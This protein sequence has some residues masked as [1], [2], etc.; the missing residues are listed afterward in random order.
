M[1]AF[2][3]F[4][5]PFIL[6]SLC[7][8]ACVLILRRWHGQE[9]NRPSALFYPDVSPFKTLKNVRLPFLRLPYTLLLI[10]LAALLLAWW[11]PPLAAKSPVSKWKKELPPLPSEGMAFYLLLDRSGSMQQP[12]PLS[13]PQVRKIDLL[14]QSTSRLIGNTSIAPQDLDQEPAVDSFASDLIGIIG[15]ARSAQ[16]LSPLTLDRARLQEVLSQ[17]HVVQNE[18]EDGTGIGYAIFKAVQLIAATKEL[19]AKET[20][21]TAQHYKPQQYD[22]QNAFLIILT[23]GFQDPNPLDQGKWLRTMGLEEAAGYAKAEGVKIYIINM[24]P[25]LEKEQFAPHRRLLESI[26]Q[27]T[28]GQFFL[29]SKANTLDALYQTIRERE[30]SLLPLGFVSTKEPSI[31]KGRDPSALVPYLLMLALLCL[32]ASTIALSTSHRVVP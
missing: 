27:M 14:K 6:S 17:F 16:V 19:S 22:I 11:N 10:A 21:G 25:S 15:F 30:Q 20:Q 2:L 26:T 23:D 7:F 8:L 13:F 5:W 29:L 32:A 9:Q 3:A 12:L 31:V 28:G 18:D 24:E 4:L 1:R